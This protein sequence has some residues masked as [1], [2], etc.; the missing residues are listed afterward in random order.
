[1]PAKG[2]AEYTEHL[3]VAVTPEMKIKVEAAARQQGVRPAVIV[4]WGLDDWLRGNAP[5]V[6]GDSTGTEGA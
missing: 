3:S 5:A 1:M 2:S 4:R 6:S